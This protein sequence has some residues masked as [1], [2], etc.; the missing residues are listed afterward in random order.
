MLYDP[1]N[2]YIEH[3]E[4]EDEEE[5]PKPMMV[6][7][8]NQYVPCIRDKSYRYINLAHKPRTFVLYKPLGDMKH[9]D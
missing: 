4:E 6:Q 7:W 8:L 9:K 2:L 3:P 1:P 5:P